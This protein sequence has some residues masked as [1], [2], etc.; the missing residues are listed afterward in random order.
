MSWDSGERERERERERESHFDCFVT[1]YHP[2]CG[3]MPGS[4]LTGTCPV[5]DAGM[6]GS[7]ILAHN[8]VIL[9]QVSGSRYQG[10]TA[11]VTQP[12]DQRKK[13]KKRQSLYA[14][15]KH[16]PLQGQPSVP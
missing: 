3:G 10:D 8:I 1:E 4:W 5:H 9:A 11:I 6:Q 13:R 12:P 2:V 7:E 16:N 14:R 15:Y